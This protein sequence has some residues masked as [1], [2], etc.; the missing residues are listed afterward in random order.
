MLDV[1]TLLAALIAVG[2]ASLSAVSPATRIPA[3]PGLPA[4]VTNDNR[5]PS[6]TPGAGTLTLKL[7]AA[8]G[9]WRPEGQPGRR[10]GS[11]RSV[12]ARRCRFRRRSSACPKAPRSA[13]VRNELADALRVHGL[14][15]RGAAACAPIDVPA[16][17]TRAV[18]FKSGPAGTYHYWATTTGMPL[19]FRAVDD[20]QLSGAFIVDPTASR[21]RTIASSSSPTGRTCTRDELKRVASADDPGAV[22][23]RTRSEVHV[24]DQ[25]PL[26]AAHRTAHLPPRRARAL[27]RRQPEHAVAH[28]APA[29]VLLRRRQPRRRRRERDASTAATPARRHAA[30]AAG[31][32]DGDDVDAG[33]SG[34]LAV[35]LPHRGLTSR[36]ADVDGRQERRQPGS[37][38]PRTTRPR[39]WPA[40]CSASRSSKRRPERGCRAA[41]GHRRADDAAM[42]ERAKR[43]GDAPAF[44]FVLRERD[45]GAVDDRV[46]VPG[47]TLVLKRGEPV[48]ITLVNE[49]PRRP[50][51]TGTAWSSRATT[52]ASTG[53]AAPASA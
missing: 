25:R 5:R 22:V 3:A 11:R 12:K 39:A 35:S 23:S 41:G 48:E 4:I 46:P 2:P 33:A 20:T 14:C 37:S 38:T 6:G 18:P 27:A 17:E 7:R 53:A 52:T 29:R 19:P 28:D 51:F 40:W 13:S 36:R 43:F 50:R 21:R 31:R 49:L 15:E 47:P 8:A 9:E 16:G 34:Q 45:R 10:C 26:L 24:P 32:D 42:R 44:G 30:D 1:P